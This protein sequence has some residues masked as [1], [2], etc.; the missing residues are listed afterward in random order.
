RDAVRALWLLLDRAPPGEVYNV[1]S[2]VPVRIGDIVEMVQVRGRV[3]VEIRTDPERLRPTDEPLL[4]GDNSKLRNATGWLPE[5]TMAETVDELLAAWRARY[6][7]KD[8]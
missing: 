7:G 4:V 2:G 1:C 6:R 8:G 3:P 5:I